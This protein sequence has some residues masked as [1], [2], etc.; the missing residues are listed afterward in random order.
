MKNIIKILLI[1]S[2]S[3]NIYALGEKVDKDSLKVYQITQEAGKLV[4]IKDY[5]GALEKLIISEKI[6]NSE[7]TI[8]KKLVEELKLV[9]LS[10]QANIYIAMGKYNEAE[11]IMDDVI[12]KVDNVTNNQIQKKIYL[13]EANVKF[14]NKKY[15]DSGDNY[16]KCLY[17]Y[18]SDINLLA[19]KTGQ[20]FREKMMMAKSML[21][22]YKKAENKEEVKKSYAV[23]VSMIFAFKVTEENKM[24]IEKDKETKESRKKIIIGLDKG[25]DAT[26]EEE[27]EWMKNH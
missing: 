3:I 26:L 5:Q 4:S 18:K 20:K 2:L 13:A 21:E 8:D 12:K 9:N 1:I 10:D 27:K 24:N 7:N 15:N 6:L 23:Y 16:K 22:A 14:T 11:A 17:L 25:I 19:M